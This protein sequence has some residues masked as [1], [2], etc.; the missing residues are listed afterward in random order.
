MEDNMKIV[1]KLMVFVFF[2][3]SASAMAEAEELLEI[4]VY[5]SPSCACC[6]KWIAHL[7]QNNFKVKDFVTNNVQ[8]KKD[9]MAV[10]KNMASCHTA[11]V[12]GYVV[13]GHVP[14]VDIKKILQLKP[15]VIGISVPGMPSGT[16]GM[17][18]GGRK[19]PYKVMSFDKENKQ[20]VFTNYEGK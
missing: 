9:E 4:E 6:S 20:Q 16:P 14:A 18:M 15:K 19:D 12:N 10:P 2:S 11:I 17:E 8:A 1:K 5:R 13:E 3:L 7:E